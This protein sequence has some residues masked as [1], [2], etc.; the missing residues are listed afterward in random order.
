MKLKVQRKKNVASM[1]IW[2]LRNINHIARHNILP[3]EAE[4][5]LANRPVELGDQLR[6]GEQRFLQIG[7]TD[8][9]RILT[10]V[11]VRREGMIRVITAHP[12]NR[13]A[14][15]FYLSQRKV[16]TKDA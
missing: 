16:D 9:G 1:F 8:Q 11:L 4:Q 14:R 2:D 10:I 12:A 15:R 3:K 5:V 7:E 6:N 13:K